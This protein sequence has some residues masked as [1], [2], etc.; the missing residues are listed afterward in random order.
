M[1]NSILCHGDCHVWLRDSVLCTC[2]V[3]MIF[4]GYNPYSR[5]TPLPAN[6]ISLD[7]LKAA[8]NIYATHLSANGKIAYDQRQYGIWYSEWDNKARQFGAWWRLFSDRLPEG[9]VEI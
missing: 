8:K 5:H 7:S 3:A 6:E 2:A 4:N 9:A 1:D